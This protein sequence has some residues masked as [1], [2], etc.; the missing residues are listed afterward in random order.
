MK[1]YTISLIIAAILVMELT[2]TVQYFLARHGAQQEMLSQARRDIEENQRV[3]KV[4]AEAEAAVRNIMPNVQRVINNTEIFSTL[5]AHMLKLNPNIVGAGVAFIRNFYKDKG[6]DGLYAPY[7]FDDR[8]ASALLAK[9]KGKPNVH[10]SHLGFDYT[11]REWFLKPVNEGKAVWSEPYVD[12]GGTHILMCS[13]AAPVVINGQTVGVFFVDIPLQEVSVLSENIHSGISRS[14]VITVLLQ[15]ISL[16][17]LSFIIW[18]AVSASRHYKESHIDPDKDRLVEQV[19]K[20]R[21]VNAR[22]TKRNQELAEKNVEL[23]RRIQAGPRN[24]DQHWFG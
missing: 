8:P 16:L 13:Y 21:E 18:R 4:K 12:K 10:F 6:H 2:G 20:L 9:D 11:D 17:V 19:S 14:G 5:T 23:Q 15:I 1:K 24:R 22:L 3:A 7:A